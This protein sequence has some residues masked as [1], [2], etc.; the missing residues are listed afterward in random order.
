M[1]QS[2]SAANEE[3]RYKVPRLLTPVQTLEYIWYQNQFLKVLNQY[4]HINE[5]TSKFKVYDLVS[6][7]AIQCNGVPLT[8]E[9]VEEAKED[10]VYDVYYADGGDIDDSY[11]DQLL[12]VQPYSLA[13][14]FE[15]SDD[16]QDEDDSNDENNWRNDYPDTEEDEGNCWRYNIKFACF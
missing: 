12:S 14:V 4:R 13:D 11:I 5:E 7:E 8:I 15:D 3:K 9:K 1:K 6:E 10:Y 2:I 16:T